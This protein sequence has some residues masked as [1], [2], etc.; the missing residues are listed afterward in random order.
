MSLEIQ[1]EEKVIPTQ[2]VKR[3]NVLPSDYNPHEIFKK[4][5]RGK[6]WEYISTDKILMDIVINDARHV[7]DLSNSIFGEGNTGGLGQIS[8]TNVAAFVDENENAYYMVTDGFHR[9]DAFIQKSEPFIDSIVLYGL[10]LEEVYDLRVLAANSVKSTGFARVIEFMQKSFEQ[11]NWYKVKGLTLLQAFSLC[12]QNTSGIRLQLEPHD[13]KDL[14]NWGIEKAHFWGRTPG[15]IFQMLMIASKADPELVRKVRVGTGGGREGSGAWN[16][17]RLKAVT[18]IIPNKYQLQQLVYQAVIQFDLVSEETQKLAQVVAYFDKAE[19]PDIIE[20]VCSNAQ[21][22]ISIADTLTNPESIKNT[23]LI[24]MYHNLAS[25]EI[26]QL[27]E[28]IKIAGEDDELKDQIYQDPKRF[29]G[30]LVLNEKLMD[31]FEKNNKAEL[32]QRKN[33]GALDKNIF[34]DS[35]DS[36]KTSG[37]SISHTTIDLENQIECLEQALNQ[38]Q[39]KNGGSSWRRRKRS[40]WKTIPGLS[41]EERKT[42]EQIFI[43]KIKIAD[44]A[45]LLNMTENRVARMVFSGVNRYFV[46]EKDQLLELVYKDLFSS[47]DQRQS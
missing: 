11:T 7:Q 1:A 42:F 32:K 9:T 38:A 4:G 46:A 12:N 27:A 37:Y 47:N 26:I 43:K 40:W 24:G 36:D 25:V 41:I 13:S 33:I 17:A 23:L 3:L 28:V 6:R 29:M 31:S 18:D 8:P 21:V 44:V 22:V 16:P 15:S 30:Q 10:S 35:I 39:E 45:K 20:L 34:D 14:K 2:I 5:L 19:E